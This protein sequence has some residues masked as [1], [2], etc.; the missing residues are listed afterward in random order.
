MNVFTNRCEAILKSVSAEIIAERVAYEVTAEVR[1]FEIGLGSS[2][3][4]SVCMCLYHP[5][6]PELEACHNLTSWRSPCLFLSQTTLSGSY[7]RWLLVVVLNFRAEEYEKIQSSDQYLKMSCNKGK[8]RHSNLGKI[9][10][11]S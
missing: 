8:Q 2:M 10:G 9:I 6:Q 3:F 4:A 7:D 1:R 11:G 5:S